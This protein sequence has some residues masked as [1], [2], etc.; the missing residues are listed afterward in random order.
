MRKRLSEAT[1]NQISVLFLTKTEKEIFKT[2]KMSSATD[3]NLKSTYSTIKYS[4][5]NTLA[6]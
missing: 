2:T 6:Y 4:L 1:E 3:S 5:E